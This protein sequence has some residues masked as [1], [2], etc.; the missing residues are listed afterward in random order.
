MKKAILF[1]AILVSA[2][3]F[4]Y[5]QEETTQALPDTSGAAL[6]EKFEEI[7][8]A[9]DGLNESY[10]ETKATVDALKKIKVSG[11]M[12]VQYQ[13]ADRDGAKS[14]A[15]GDF[16]TT[17][18]NRFLL[19]RGRIKFNYD[20]DLTNYVLQFD[21]TEKGFAIKDAY[22]AVREPWLKAFELWG[23][24]F[25]RPFGFE[26][27]YS[28]SNRESPERARMYQTLFPGERD[29]GAK[30]EIRPT[31]GFLSYFNLKAGLFN[32]N[33]ESASAFSETDNVKDFIGR[34]GFSVPFLEENFAVDGGVS[35]YSGKTLVP[36]GKKIFKVNGPTTVDSVSTDKYADRNYVGADVQL[37]YDIPYIGGM[38]LRG[39]YI[40]GKQP[41]QPTS[42]TSQTTA[43]TDHIYLRNFAGYY[44]MYV[45][46]IGTDHQLVVKYDVYDP[47]KDVTGDNIGLS[48]NKYLGAADLKYTTIGIGLVHHWDANVKFVFYYDL[49]KN[50][51]SNL[52]GYT[53]DLKDNVFTVR[54]QYKF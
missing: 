52:K 14:V 12:Q 5:A 13:S 29:L 31:E 3:L 1:L 22:V 2:N 48:A 54:M 47:N 21:A 27:E 9:L 15:G 44:L 7:K 49:V 6:K 4:V 45:Q 36:A 10:L 23:G 18:H 37:Y 11:Y 25:N 33:G 17:L 50:E 30:L 28:S 39:E 26:I 51:T 19:R 38:T 53:E 20:N 46:N 35:L 41:A 24:I 40:T 8:G 34:L 43:F 16:G 42:S 32:G